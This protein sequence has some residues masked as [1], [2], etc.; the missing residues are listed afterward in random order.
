MYG[1]F[2]SG[3]DWASTNIGVVFC[4]EC[5]GVHRSLG[6]HISKVKSLTLDRWEEEYVEVNVYL[7]FSTYD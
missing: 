6:V 3:P 4:I 1:S 5:S 2:S 7:L